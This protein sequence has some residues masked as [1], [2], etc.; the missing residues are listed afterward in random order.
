[1]AIVLTDN[2]FFSGLTNL[3]L[4]MRIYATN[5]SKKADDFVDS[6]MTDILE[7]GNQ[8]LFPYAD[9]PSVGDYSETSSL[10]TV[11]K[12]TVGEE[13]IKVDQKKVIKASYSAYILDAA[14]TSETGMND[15]IGYLLGLMES[16][17][18]AYLYDVI[19]NDL[20]TKEF[21]PG[22]GAAAKQLHSVNMI[23]LTGLTS[24]AD[25][26]GAES[27]NAKNLVEAIQTDID[28][29]QVYNTGYNKKGLKEAVDWKDL[30][31]VILAKYRYKEVVEVL[32]S[33][34][35][36]D[37]I[38]N[39]FDKPDLLVVPEIKVPENRTQEIAWIMHKAAY[40]L[41]YKFVVNGSFFDVSNL[42]VNHFL[43]FWYGKGWLD[44][45]PV[46]KLIKN[47]QPLVVESA[48][49]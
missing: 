6:F 48:E 42:C 15:F 32:A 35:N 39:D 26:N 38:E 36:S 20:F 7:R 34:L 3:A 16:A 2:E 1:M 14:F 40:Q 30:R 11:T 19:I 10:L 28:N 49:A 13:A 5:T 33:L 25:I 27:R 43:H 12:N 37:Q 18:T 41:F 9:L 45:L 24:L 31:V 17:K 8:K 21:G 46:C 22:S 47:E 29:I 44:A 23:S 4:F